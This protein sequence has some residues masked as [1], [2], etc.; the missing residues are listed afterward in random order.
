[1]GADN[2]ITLSGW[3]IPKIT[4]YH[5]RAFRLLYKTPLCTWTSICRI[6]F[7]PRKGYA[8][9]WRSNFWHIAQSVSCPI[10]V[11]GQP[12]RHRHIVGRRPWG[13]RYCRCRK[14]TSR[15]W[16]SGERGRNSYDGRLGLASF[17][18]HFLTDAPH[19]RSHKVI[20][21][22]LDESLFARFCGLLR[23]L[24]ILNCLHHCVYGCHHLAVVLLT[25]LN[26]PIFDVWLSIV[27][28]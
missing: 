2:N 21:S 28:V 7:S 13:F 10:L 25:Q 16:E 22:C 3:K 4:Q 14:L 17:E 6:F 20:S 15:Q 23:L 11:I 12:N 5:E 26:W 8:A 18:T 27:W 9:P 24:L 19:S 1:M